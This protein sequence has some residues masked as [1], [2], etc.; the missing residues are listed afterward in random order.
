MVDSIESIRGLDSVQKVI[1]QISSFD[2][3]STLLSTIESVDTDNALAMAERYEL[4]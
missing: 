2:A 1:G 3:H 4:C